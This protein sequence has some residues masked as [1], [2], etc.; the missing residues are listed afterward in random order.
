MGKF[1]KKDSILNYNPKLVCIA[2]SHAI[3]PDGAH[4]CR[5]LKVLKADFRWRRRLVDG[6]GFHKMG[7]AS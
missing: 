6:P 5:F 4:K 3:F 7:V 1:A 2:I